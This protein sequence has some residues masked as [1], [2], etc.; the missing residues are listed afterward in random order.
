MYQ[1][2]CVQR[3]CFSGCWAGTLKK[4]IELKC[5]LERYKKWA[6]L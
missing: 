4:L 6:V 1:L 3:I 5:H 2:K